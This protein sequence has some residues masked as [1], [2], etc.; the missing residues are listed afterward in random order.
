MI[1]RLLGGKI[2]SIYVNAS[3][4]ATPLS[5]AQVPLPIPHESEN[6]LFL[7]IHV[8][9]KSFFDKKNSD[10]TAVIVWIHGG[11]LTVGWKDAQ[12]DPAGLLTQSVLQT[13]KEVIFMALNYRVSLSSRKNHSI[14][15]IRRS[16]ALL[17]GREDYLYNLIAPQTLVSSTNGL[18]SSGC[19]R[20]SNHSEKTQRR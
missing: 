2:N 11:G 17:G 3:E 18:L 12:Y 4:H 8:P 20:I 6:C 14:L 15:L 7:N 1:F 19:N 5:R 13:G 10:G 16:W 9:E